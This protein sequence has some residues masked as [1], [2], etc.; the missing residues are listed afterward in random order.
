MPSRQDMTNR[1]IR[2]QQAQAASQGKAAYLANKPRKSDI[3][4]A[5]KTKR[6]GA[7]S[8]RFAVMPRP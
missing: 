6:H 8:G 5:R 7:G 4:A 1:A 3:T 2:Q